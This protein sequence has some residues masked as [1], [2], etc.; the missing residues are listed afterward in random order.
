MGILG[1]LPPE[2]MLARLDREVE[3]W[4]EADPSTPVRPALHMIAVMATGDPGADGKYRL[5]LPAD[6]IEEVISWAEQRDAIVIVDIQPGRSTVAEELRP[7]LPYLERPDVHLALD[8]EWRM[9]GDAVPGNQVGAMH[10]DEV[11]DAI[12][13]LATLVQEH[14]LPPKVLVVHRFTQAML[15][16]A[17]HIRENPNVQVVLNMDG[18]GP[19][20]AK[21][22][23]YR[24]F[25]APAPIAY[26][27]FKLFYENDR[28]GDSRL[29]TP[30]EVLALT[31][32]PVY[33]QYQ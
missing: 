33:I 18:W 13:A 22:S 15:P 12:D 9:H 29:M 16:D 10:A 7:L 6:A 17:H 26:K 4:K 20:S 24:S 14:G 21:V 31:P 30:A 23:S 3:A 8:P 25:V 1:E 2:E 19:P 32:V 28:R 5:R 27:G 11:N